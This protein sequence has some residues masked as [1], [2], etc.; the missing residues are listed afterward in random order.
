[1]TGMPA[2]EEDVL[3]RLEARIEAV[4][5]RLAALLREKAEFDS[6]LQTLASERDQAVEEARAAREEAAA[7][8]EENEHLR[9]RQREAFSRIKALL[10]QVEQMELPES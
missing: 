2:D 9:A 7:L 6:R 3:A 5:Q 4:S 8:R 1:M 10:H